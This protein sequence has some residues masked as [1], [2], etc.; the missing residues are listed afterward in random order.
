LLISA[1]QANVSGQAESNFLEGRKRTVP[2]RL[3]KSLLASQTV[4]LLHPF[5]TQ[6]QMPEVITMHESL[7][8]T[9]FSASD[10]RVVDGLSGLSYF[11]IALDYVTSGQKARTCT[12]FT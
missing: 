10:L 3:R 6:L 12:R 7:E 1:S 4:L 8:G 5:E 9:S 2:K 11:R